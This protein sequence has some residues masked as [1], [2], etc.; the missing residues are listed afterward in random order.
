MIQIRPATP[1]GVPADVSLAAVCPMC[2]T[3]AS[4]SASDVEGGG[5][6]RC[7]RCGQ[8][9]HSRRLAAVAAYAAWVTNRD[10][11]TAAASMEVTT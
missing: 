2:C 10:R 11:V 9:W 1:A 6:W 7:G 5:E 8:H 3:R 4:I